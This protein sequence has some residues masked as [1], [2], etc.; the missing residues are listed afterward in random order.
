MSIENKVKLRKVTINDINFLFNTRIEYCN[1][2]SNET[3]PNF[4]HHKK[5]VTKFINDRENHNYI[6]WYIIQIFDKNH[7]V[8]VGVMPLKKNYEFGYQTLKKYRNQGITQK[9]IQIFIQMYGKEKL[10]ARSRPDNKIS[11]HILVKAG[12]ELTDYEFHFKKN[13]N[14]Y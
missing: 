2:V 5:F 4:K 11:H 1:Y 13:K 10:W 7:W 14:R 12:L 6:E 8:D 9:A 3:A